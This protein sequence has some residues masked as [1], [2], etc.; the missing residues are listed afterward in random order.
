VPETSPG[1]RQ[2]TLPA[3]TRATAIKDSL[4]TLPSSPG[5]PR[6]RGGL[7]RRRRRGDRA[8]DRRR[9]VLRDRRDAGA[10]RARRSKDD[11]KKGKA[12]AIGA[13]PGMVD[14][15]KAVIQERDERPR[16]ANR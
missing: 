12:I 1:A 16:A 11:V 5:S 3:F 2:T 13:R 9:H 15:V 4:L 10:V 7:P 8:P 14:A 6:R